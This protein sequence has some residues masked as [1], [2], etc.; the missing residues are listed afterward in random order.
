[1]RDRPND[2][3]RRLTEQRLGRKLSPDEVVDHHDQDKTNNSGANL[4]VQ[5]RA[6]HTTH[7]NKPAERGLGRL[8]KALLVTTGKSPKQ[9]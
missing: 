3:H 9:Y 5:T 7:H 8:R 2:S 1:M 6:A 4:T